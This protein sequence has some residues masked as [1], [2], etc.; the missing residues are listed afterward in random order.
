MTNHLKSSMPEEISSRQLGYLRHANRSCG[1]SYHS[2]CRRSSG[3]G[4]A[5][6]LRDMGLLYLHDGGE[7]KNQGR[8]TWRTTAAG[9]DLVE[10]MKEGE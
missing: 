9:A 10:K 3:V 5:K 6:G 2:S 7:H 8:Y 4:T 1:L